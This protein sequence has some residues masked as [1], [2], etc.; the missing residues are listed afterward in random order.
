MGQI[1]TRLQDG[2]AVDWSQT[3]H[4]LRNMLQ[5][6]C[7]KSSGFVLDVYLSQ[8]TQYIELFDELDKPTHI[9]MLSLSDADCVRRLQRRRVPPGLWQPEDTADHAVTRVKEF[10]EQFKHLE[11]HISDISR[12]YVSSAQR[13]EDIMKLIAEK[14]HTWAPFYA[15]R[16]V[17]LPSDVLSGTM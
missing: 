14:L 15:V 16:H 6:P 7:V 1:R 9:V 8:A 4:C 13:P 11:E 5:D 2:L 12:I 3:V 17:P 10:G